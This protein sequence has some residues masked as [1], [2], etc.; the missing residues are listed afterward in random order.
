MALENVK[1]FPDLHIDSHPT[2]LNW[3]NTTHIGCGY[4]EWFDGSYREREN[5]KLV[6]K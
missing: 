4:T 6:R 3:S 2:Q 1:S 5:Y